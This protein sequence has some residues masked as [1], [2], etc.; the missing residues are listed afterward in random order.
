MSAT[1]GSVKGPP[2]GLG[3]QNGEILAGLDFSESEMVELEQQV[4]VVR[5]ED[6]CNDGAIGH[7][8]STGC[9]SQTAHVTD[10]LVK[11]FSDVA[12]MT[13][14]V[15][16][17]ISKRHASSWVRFLVMV[18]VVAGAAL[19]AWAETGT[20]SEERPLQLLE[21]LTAADQA[22]E[23]GD[24]DGA[25][26]LSTKALNAATDTYGEQHEL[27]LRGMHSVALINKVQGRHDVAIPIFKKLIALNTQIN[28]EDDFSN[29]VAMGNLGGALNAIGR[30]G[31]SE[32]LL[33][34][35]YLRMVEQLG[36]SHEATVEFR[37]EL[38]K[39]Y[40]A[41]QKFDS[42][43]KLMQESIEVRTAKLGDNHPNVIASLVAL[44]EITA[45]NDQFDFADSLLSDALERAEQIQHHELMTFVRA[46]VGNLHHKQGDLVEAEIV[47]RR[48]LPIHESKFGKS[49]SFTLSLRLSL[50]RL[51][52]EQ[53]RFE[54]GYEVVTEVYETAIQ[55]LDFG[56]RLIVEAADH[57]QNLLIDLGQLQQAH[58]F[59]ESFYKQLLEAFGPNDS[60]VVAAMHDLASIYRQL[61]LFE[62]AETNFKEAVLLATQILGPEHT[63]TMRL[64]NA[65]AGT[66]KDQGKLK[67]AELLQLENLQ[68]TTNILGEN[69]ADTLKS[70]N[71]LGII[72]EAQGRFVEARQLY[73]QSL[74]GARTVLGETSSAVM[75]VTNNLAG[76]LV[77]QGEYGRAIALYKSNLKNVRARYGIGHPKSATYTA[78]LANAHLSQG[79]YELAQQLLEQSLAALTENLGDRHPIT[80]AQINNLAEL[81]G[82][83]NRPDLAE[84]LFEK[85]VDLA[86]EVL[87]RQHPVTLLYLH[88]QAAAFQRRLNYHAAEKSFRY[89]LEQRT[90]LLGETHP[91]TMT[92]RNNLAAMLFELGDIN[93]SVA[94]YRV[95]FPAQKATLGINH[96]STLKTQYNLALANHR[97]G[98]R[99]LA[100]RGYVDVLTQTRRSMGQ[101]H[102]FELAVL[103]SL[104]GLHYENGNLAK[105]FST[106]STFLDA[107]N[108][109]LTKNIWGASD[110]TRKA[111]LE[112]QDRFRD[113]FFSAAVA[114]KSS[115]FST[116]SNP[117]TELLRFS[118]ARKGYLL[119]I[120]AEIK[121]RS[122]ATTDPAIEQWLAKLELKNTQLN[123]VMQEGWGEDKKLR[124]TIETEIERLQA[125]IA[126]HIS[127]IKRGL[128][129]V[130]P[131]DV[132]NAL[133]DH[134][135]LLDFHVFKRIEDRLQQL[136]AIWVDPNL[137]EPIQIID[138][139]DFAD[140]AVHIREYRSALDK[141]D[142]ESAA[143][144]AALL[145]KRIWLPVRKFAVSKSE[146]FTI[147]DDKL[148][149]LPIAALID[150]DGRYLVERKKISYLASPRDLIVN[151]VLDTTAGES[152]VFM[153]PLYEPKPSSINKRSKDRAV[154]VSENLSELRFPPLPGTLIEGKKVARLLEASNNPHVEF[155]DAKASEARL[156]G[157]VSPRILHLAT[158][159]FFL[160]S[161]PGI[162]PM[163]RSG[164]ALTNANVAVVTG[165]QADGLLTAYEAMS[166]Q[167]RGTELVVLSACETGVGEIH[168]GEGIYGLQR[169][170]LQ[171]GSRAVLFTLWKI[172]DR[173]TV[174]FME[175]FY[176]HFLN[177]TAAQEA[178][179]QTQLEMLLDPTWNDPLFWAGFALV[180]LH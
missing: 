107:R 99:R 53:Y 124:M 175:K 93:A 58:M 133:A 146:I 157:M 12:G 54:A 34:K 31:E 50:G 126:S 21:W 138:L 78:N 172:S 35:A 52:A 9:L 140:I 98:K 86:Q 114:S 48:E 142:E 87:G 25:L 176:Q 81:Y 152:A 169:A 23:S 1:P 101:A 82:S 163:F 180:T 3:E 177:G 68:V 63:E 62:L 20:A 109:F 92:T 161:Y 16:R 143:E 115:I 44:A 96:P 15:R 173:A 150:G 70:K 111:Y 95:N 144:L 113:D 56:H 17:Q 123:T 162:N 41:Q 27:T 36:L 167:L 69:N 74:A 104:A 147:P 5:E 105:A 57:R 60:R 112:E 42:A 64:Q 122:S 106:W 174:V 135:A 37:D 102:P 76:V 47:F 67:E 65:L 148:H 14:R 154:T 129:I 171:A 125:Q 88:N 117:A 178:L 121:A 85:C 164:L 132:V 97:L 66:Y 118:V 6:C 136:I 61:G 165:G 39:S 77:S 134:Q 7:L 91:Q 28:G 46:A 11:E 22:F 156:R 40:S 59:Q 2:P 128:H 84:P 32:S 137:E 160:G 127:G 45:N 119:Q 110:E 100:E 108:E 151:E 153:D 13:F 120:G 51:L 155:S 89:V 103:N 8:T 33:L 30:P 149:L 29:F 83:Q 130:H 141:Q 24:M 90:A 71:D 4:A 72:Y 145:Y 49:H 80:I 179:R 10:N 19:P 55:S 94:L 38:T 168:T 170:F 116:R 158:H 43:T 26:S 18:L 131:A 159:G 75:S 139:G 166:L 79:S 73:E